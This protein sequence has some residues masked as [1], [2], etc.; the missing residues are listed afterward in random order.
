MSRHFSAAAIAKLGLISTTILL[1]GACSG[2]ASEGVVNSGS[3]AELGGAAGGGS[4]ASRVSTP[5]RTSIDAGPGSAVDT[6]LPPAADAG[7]SPAIDAASPA[8][9]AGNIVTDASHAGSLDAAPTI[10]GALVITSALTLSTTTVAPGETVTG[11]VTFTNEGANDVIVQSVVVAARPPGGTHAGGPFDDFAPTSAAQTLAPGASLTLSATRTFSAADPTGS[12][13]IYPTWEDGTGVWHDGPDSWI[14]VGAASA[15]VDAGPPVTASIAPLVVPAVGGAGA[16][17]VTTG[18]AGRLALH[19]VAVWGIEDF[20]TTSFGVEQHENR[21]A[22]AATIAA[23]GGNVIRLRVLA[24]EYIYLS[25]M[26]SDANY[27]QWIKDWVA[28]AEAHGL[29]VQICWWDSLDSQHGTND[30]NWATAYGTAFPMMTDVHNALKLADGS[31]DPAVF[32]EPFN[33]PNNVSW[34]QWLTAMEATVSEFRSTAGYQGLLVLDTTTWSHDYSDTYMGQIEAYDAGLTASG[35]ANLAFARHDYCN[36]Y[37]NEWNSGTWISDTG[38]SETAHVMY[39]TEYG[40]YNGPG[41]QSDAWS[42]GITGYFKTD[43]LDRSNVAGADAFLFGNWF[44]ANAM[45]N[46]PVG[47]SPTT[48]GSDVESWLSAY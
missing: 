27:L 28:A 3:P 21:D 4:D 46:D 1:A 10:D 18:G 40:N 45:S 35:R 30:A 19:G 16:H 32:Y 41:N 12:W 43:L 48:W 33:E 34:D 17:L 6:G 5:G 15:T 23:W 36:D 9:D 29:Y 24:D 8:S 20:I 37:G 44:D 47:A 31:D 14:K 7:K 42:A 25:Y 11:K 39:E 22:I 26:Q 38:G 13:D 2:A